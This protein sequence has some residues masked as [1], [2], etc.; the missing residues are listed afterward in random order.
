M[1]K[2]MKKL[3]LWLSLPFGL[4]IMITCFTGGALVFEKEV[5]ESFYPDLYFVK[6]VGKQ[7]LPLEELLTQ[8]AT[9]LPDSVSITKVTISPDAKR[10]YQVALSK[11]RRASLYVDPYTGEV[12]GYYQRMPFFLFMFRAHRWLLDGMKPAGEIFWGKIIVGTSTLLFVIV[13]LSGLIIWLPRSLKSLS[14]RLKVTM[15][16]GKHRFWYD[17]HVSGGFY[18]TLMLLVMSLTGLTWSFPWYRKGFYA[19]F[20]VELHQPLPGKVADHSSGKSNPKGGD[21]SE[22]RPAKDAKEKGGAQP[23]NLYGKSSIYLA[24][25]T[26]FEQVNRQK[27]DNSTITITN[28]LASLSHAGWGNQRGADNYYFHPRKGE[29]TKIERYEEQP[30][31]AKIRGWIYSVHVGSFGGIFTRILFCLASFLGAT[32]PITGYYLWIK[33]SFLRKRRR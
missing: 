24:W 14:N 33:R 26:V 25:Q 3:H 9:T 7:P 15:N 23:N 13:L 2:F 17:L 5:T 11:P 32:L 28:G 18:I 1:R 10:T 4:I 19:L 30:S 21:K 27:K 20:G 31:S 16:K 6:E 29:I 22:S 12:K 8:V